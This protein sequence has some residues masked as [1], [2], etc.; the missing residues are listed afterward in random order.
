MTSAPLVAVPTSA[1]EAV[2]ALRQIVADLHRQLTRYGLVVW[3]A[4]NVSARVP[5]HELMVI[6]PSGVAYDELTAAK[7]PVRSRIRWR[8]P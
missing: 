3:T 8:R 2:D 5:G 6:K 4:G 1:R 7:R